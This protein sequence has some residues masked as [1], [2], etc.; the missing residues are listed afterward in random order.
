MRFLTLLVVI[1]ILS[2]PLKSEAND[3]IYQSHDP[4][5]YSTETDGVITIEGRLEVFKDSNMYRDCMEGYFESKSSFPPF[6]ILIKKK[7]FN[8]LGGETAFIGKLVRIT[9]RKKTNKDYIVLKLASKDNISFIS[10]DQRKALPALV[11]VENAAKQRLFRYLMKCFNKKNFN[12]AK[13]ELKKISD[14]EISLMVTITDPCPNDPPKNDPP[15]FMRIEKNTFTRHYQGQ[16]YVWV[17][18]V[19]E[20]NH[21]S[22]LI[23]EV[24]AVTG[25]ILKKP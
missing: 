18:S 23:F 8:L 3:M 9:V 24:N 10:E 21:H 14:K 16:E 25:D 12:I 19:S 1:L 2:N 17:F 7:D 6:F 20:Q 22:N 11:L 15:Y 4:N 5:L 13:G